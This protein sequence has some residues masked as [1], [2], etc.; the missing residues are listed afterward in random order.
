MTPCI[1]SLQN[2][3]IKQ[4]VRLRDRRGRNDQG[5][6]LI[7]GVR[8]IVRAW[9]ARVQ[10][11]EVFYCPA[12]CQAA[13]T[14]WLEEQ[15]DRLPQVWEVTPAVF[16][17]FAFGD[18]AEG[19]IAV[20]FPP[21]AEL[22]RIPV[23][24]GVIAVVEGVEKPGNIGA[25]LRTA[26]AAGVQGMI[27]ADGGTDLFNP[28]TIRASLGA[29]FTLPVAAAPS[30]QTLA[31]LRCHEFRILAARVDGALPYTQA[32]YRGRCA[33]VLGSEAAGLTDLWRCDEVQAVSL[34]MCGRVDSLNVSAAAAVLFYEAL[35]Q[36]SGS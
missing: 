8:E 28:N 36:R 29:L 35:R 23:T 7:D 31:W 6:I 22:D 25:M 11:D 2:P 32:D 30:H 4:A 16:E 17:K 12:R 26:D 15:R 19:L 1:T 10:L 27:V 3:R 9:E 14:A 13:A 5:R 20:A 33:I 24:E 21:P 34:P 18:R